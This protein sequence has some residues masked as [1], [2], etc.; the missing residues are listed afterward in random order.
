MRRLAVLLALLALSGCASYWQS[1]GEKSPYF[2]IP[3]G[4]TVTLTQAVRVPPQSATVYIQFGR[5]VAQDQVHE[6]TPYC[7]LELKSVH[8]SFQQVE[9]G[10]FVITDWEHE[11]SSIVSRAP[12]VVPVRATAAGR[13]MEANL[14]LIGGEDLRFATTFDLR[15]PPD[16][17]VYDLVCESW[18]NPVTGNFLSL[19]EM[20]RATW[21]L[22]EFHL[23]A[24]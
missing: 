14:G 1:L 23:A 13:I 24:R 9:P 17:K 2:D 11:A 5:A 6:Y 10:T 4:S 20:R 3:V 7:R 18:Q 15:T 16:S 8:N 22:L 12:T 19:D 21:P